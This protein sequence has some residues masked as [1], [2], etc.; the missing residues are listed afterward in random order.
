MVFE[1]YFIDNIFQTR[2]KLFFKIIATLLIF[3]MF[4]YEQ[5]LIKIII[6]K[7]QGPIIGAKAKNFIFL[8]LFYEKMQKS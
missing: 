3:I 7:K 6:I 5:P 1:D 8:Y 4:F 2:R